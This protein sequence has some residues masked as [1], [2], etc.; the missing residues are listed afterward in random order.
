MQKNVKI[1]NLPAP[2][3]NTPDKITSYAKSANPS[4]PFSALCPSLAAR[5]LHRKNAQMDAYKERNPSRR[6]KMAHVTLSKVGS[7]TKWAVIGAVK[8]RESYSP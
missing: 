4:P 1:A 5:P 7:S 3:P 8:G 6:F 2:K